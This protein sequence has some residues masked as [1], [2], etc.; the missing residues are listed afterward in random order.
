MNGTLCIQDKI[1]DMH[2]R[3]VMI[4]LKC[5]ATV[6]KYSTPYNSMTDTCTLILSA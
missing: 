6:I 4:A 2:N 3:N 5:M 1:S